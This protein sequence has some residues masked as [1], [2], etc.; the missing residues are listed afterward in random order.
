MPEIPAQFMKEFI[1]YFMDRVIS[2]SQR[3]LTNSNLEIGSIDSYLEFY[4]IKEVAR[5]LE[6]PEIG[7]KQLQEGKLPLRRT[8]FDDW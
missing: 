1:Y 7:V 5:R 3:E 2:K 8:V 4:D 6:L